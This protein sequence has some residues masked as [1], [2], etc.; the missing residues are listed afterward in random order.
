[1]HAGLSNLEIRQ[2][3]AEYSFRWSTLRGALQFPAGVGH[4]PEKHISFQVR[5]EM[6]QLRLVVYTPGLYTLQLA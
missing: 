6:M 5:I 1:M 2:Q 3:S 4:K